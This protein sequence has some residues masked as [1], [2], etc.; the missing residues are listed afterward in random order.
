MKITVCQ[1]DNRD[2]YRQDAYQ[3]LA[4]HTSGVSPDLLLLPELGF[5]DWL[6][7]TREVSADRW[8]RS[9]DT[10]AKE[11]ADLARYGAR[12]AIGTRPVVN[13]AASRRNEVYLWN[14]D[15]GAVRV[16]EKYYLPDH[17]GFY[18]HSWYDRGE[19]EFNIVRVRDARLGVQVCTEMW[20]F[21]W[22]RMLGQSNADVIG[23]PRATGHASLQGWIAGGK[24]AA[25]VAG[26]YCISSN[27]W[28]PIGSTANLGGG[29]W[30]IA[31]DGEL[32]ALTSTDEPFLTVDIDLAIARSAKNT[33]PRYV[34]E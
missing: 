31:P 8:Q 22:A 27:S 9:V 2:G 11:I 13:E 34:R 20:F 15:R 23:V 12:A 10:H 33:Y 19:R 5:D 3:R 21:E 29:G 4:E 14:P 28:A 26:A 7:A 6:A 1:I 17:E 25:V 32:L 16:K 18:E 30:I 24:A